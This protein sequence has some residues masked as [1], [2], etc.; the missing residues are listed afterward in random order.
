ML[1]IKAKIMTITAK[2][3]EFFNNIFVGKMLIE[4]PVL[5]ANMAVMPYFYVT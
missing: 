2:I 4:H 3:D 5:L 1:I